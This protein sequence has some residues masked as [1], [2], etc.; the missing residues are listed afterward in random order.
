M[1]QY[2]VPDSGSKDSVAVRQI[3]DKDH[4]FCTRPFRIK[5]AQEDVYLSV[6]VSFSLYVIV[7]EML[8]TSRVI[9]KFE[10]LYASFHGAFLV[11]QNPLRFSLPM[12]VQ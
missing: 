9:L 2:D 7:P 6:M 8:F 5:Y 4:S 11:G 12:V 3:K 10:L 1:V